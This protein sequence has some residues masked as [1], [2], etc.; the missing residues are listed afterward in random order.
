MSALQIWLRIHSRR[1]TQ[2][3]IDKALMEY[4]QSIERQRDKLLNALICTTGWTK[5]YAEEKGWNPKNASLIW[6]GIDFAEKAMDE[7]MSKKGS[8]VTSP[9]TIIA[10][11]QAETES[12]RQDAERY[13]WLKANG[14]ANSKKSTKARI[15]KDESRK[16]AL[17]DFAYWCEESEVD[18]VIDQAKEEKC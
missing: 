15:Y 4:M 3:A 14:A 7:A 1:L 16:T 9:N 5:A 13:R 12:L 8:G 10:D 6:I 2:E 17:L 11:L 18:A